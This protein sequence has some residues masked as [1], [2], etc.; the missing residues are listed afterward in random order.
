MTSSEDSLLASLIKT[1]DF[2]IVVYIFSW[3]NAYI[4]DSK[5]PSCQFVEGDIHFVEGYKENTSEEER[6][7]PY[8]LLL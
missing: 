7:K 5:T 8:D 4:R 3:R 1:C 6:S 2:W